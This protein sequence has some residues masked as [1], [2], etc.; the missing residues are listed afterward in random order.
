[1]RCLIRP[2]RTKNASQSV[3]GGVIDLAESL[4][5]VESI[6]ECLDGRLPL[7][8]NFVQQRGG[9]TA[10]DCRNAQDPREEPECPE[11]EVH[12]FR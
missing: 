6:L 4:K 5:P 3:A 10:G 8:G 1:M 7:R 12:F 2:R 11:T 9:L